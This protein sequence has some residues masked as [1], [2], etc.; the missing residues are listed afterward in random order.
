MS[1]I[2]GL[3]VAATQPVVLP[4]CLQYQQL[5]ESAQLQGNNMK[6]VQVQISQ[7]RQAIQ[8]LQSQIGN[9][10]KQVCSQCQLLV[11]VLFLHH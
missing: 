5:Q 1:L 2:L 7:L 3:E 4:L 11:G 8:R 9:L 10:R 6:E